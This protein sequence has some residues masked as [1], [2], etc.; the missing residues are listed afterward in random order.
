MT[1]T[2]SNMENKIG[3]MEG[4]GIWI[5]VHV[6]KVRMASDTYPI[7]REIHSFGNH[8]IYGEWTVCKP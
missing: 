3:W 8:C 1:V 7:K 2:R 4:H 6:L 5:T